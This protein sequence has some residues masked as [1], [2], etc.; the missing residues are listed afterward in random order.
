MFVFSNLA[1][2]LDGKIATQDRSLFLLGT[3]EDRKQMQVL[4]KKSDAI[5]MGASTLRTYQRPCLIAGSKTQP[6]NVL[7]SSSL[8]GVSPE[9]PFFKSTQIQRV[10]FLGQSIS[11][12]RH[13]QFERSSKIIVL[14]KP[15]PKSPIARQVIR[16][17]EKLGIKNL[18]VE[19]GGGVMWDFVQYNLIDEYHVTLTPRVLGGI[20]SPTLVDG[21]GFT[22]KNSLQLKLKHC[23]IVKDEIF[24]TYLKR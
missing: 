24:L 17:L 21:L 5:L 2:S 23:R 3:P 19:G 7:L 6:L 20:H 14:K 12:S 10:L 18:L 16:S 8:E 1:M 22:P 4:R 15:T 13:R 11:P 9:W